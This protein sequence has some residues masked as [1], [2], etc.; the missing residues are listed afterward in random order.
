MNKK[1]LGII[2]AGAAALSS[3]IF[4]AP[5]NAVQ[6]D[7][8]VEVTIQPGIFLRTFQNVKLQITQG[9]LGA[10][11]EKDFNPGV[12]DTDGTTKL[13]L[14]P[15]PQVGVGTQPTVTKKVN[16]LFAVWSN[17]GKPI[18][19]TVTPVANS[20][21]GAPKATILTNTADPASEILLTNV[22]VNNGS[23]TPVNANTPIVGGVDLTFDVS[24]ASAGVHTGGKLT[25]EALAQP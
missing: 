4:A 8:N 20:A 15:R 24:A 6:Q 19:V 25:V 21:A 10:A 16:E 5:A 17:G 7:V 13:T 1:I 3:A 22:T 11:L 9:E 12:T 2:A 18:N 23:G 14:L